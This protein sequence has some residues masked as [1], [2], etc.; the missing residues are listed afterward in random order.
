MGEPDTGLSSFYVI[1][2]HHHLGKEKNIKNLSPTS[3]EGSYHLCRAILFGNQ[4]KPGLV[5]ELC[6]NPDEYR[7]EIPQNES[8]IPMQNHLEFFTKLGNAHYGRDL[9][10]MFKDTQLIDQT[11]VFPMRDIYREKKDTTY[12]FSNDKVSMVVNKF[13]NSLR[14]IGFG[15]VVPSEGSIALAEVNRMVIENGLR[16]LKI[17]PKNDNFPIVS[18]D[19]VSLLKTTAKFGIPVISHT[20]F[21]NEVEEFQEVVN[22]TIKSIL[23]DNDYQIDRETIKLLNNI[24]VVIGHCGWHTSPRLFEILSHPCIYGEIS[25]IKGEVVKKFFKVAKSSFN[26]D[27]FYIETIKDLISEKIS[28]K[29]IRDVYF[30]PNRKI[31]W[32]NKIMFGSDYPFL[33]QN[34]SIDVI[35]QLLHVD[36]SGDE[37]D[38]QNFLGYN[39]LNIIPS[40]YD[41]PYVLLKRSPNEILPQPISL[42]PAK[43]FNNLFITE[44]L[45]FIKEKKIKNVAV[46]ILINDNLKIILNNLILSL[47][48]EDKATSFLIQSEFHTIENILNNLDQ[49]NLIRN[50]AI[51]SALVIDMNDIK[52]LK[53]NR[54]SYKYVMSNYQS[55]FDN[56]NKPEV[57]INKNISSFFEIISDNL[58]E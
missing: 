6:D 28:E 51:G 14:L 35:R 47:I 12:A 45:K 24:K 43:K 13:P 7:Y 46:D 37:I 32:S 20:S 16:G 44:L 15:R 34:Q 26:V 17:H 23:K 27:Y 25:G 38:I 21:L 42:R 4:W 18:E 48:K 53:N 54:M 41:S 40:N 52:E 31:R 11:V 33:D 36:F 56:I 1:D 29:H 57:V 39:A 50:S 30:N 58:G 10:K 19:M 55:L 9:D 5:N 8:F 3:P 22:L 2:F 49:H